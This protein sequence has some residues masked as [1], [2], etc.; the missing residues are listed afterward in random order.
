MVV[1]KLGL[2][3]FNKIEKTDL[4]HWTIDVKNLINSLEN[5]KDDW[6]QDLLSHA[7]Y[8]LSVLEY[9]KSGN[10]NAAQNMMNFS[11]SSNNWN[12]NNK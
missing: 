2:L 12:Q 6:S 3:M 4:V 5:K 11:N 10:T 8:Y 9:I 1:N 7:K